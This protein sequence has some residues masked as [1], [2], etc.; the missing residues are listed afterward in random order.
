MAQILFVWFG[1]EFKSSATTCWT[2]GIQHNI[3]SALFESDKPDRRL[4][5]VIP[6]V[7]ICIEENIIRHFFSPLLLSCRRLAEPTLENCLLD[8]SIR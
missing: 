7:P 6:V 4:E 1:Q 8:Q 2:I 3:L 5:R